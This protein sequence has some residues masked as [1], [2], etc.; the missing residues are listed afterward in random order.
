LAEL[1]KLSGEPHYESIG[2]CHGFVAHLEALNKVLEKT[3]DP[4]RKG[5]IQSAIDDARKELDEIKK[6]N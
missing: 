5:Q 6:K 3:S 2:G 1:H 4:R